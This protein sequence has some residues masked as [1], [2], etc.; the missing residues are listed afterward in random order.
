MGCSF[1]QWLVIN[2]NPDSHPWLTLKS[3]PSEKCN[4]WCEEESK[5]PLAF[6]IAFYCN[7]LQAKYLLQGLC[8]SSCS[9]MMCSHQKHFI[10]MS[11]NFLSEVAL[12]HV[13][14]HYSRIWKVE[15]LLHSM[16]AYANTEVSSYGMYIFYFYSHDA[17]YTS[18]SGLYFC[19]F[20]KLHF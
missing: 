19:S 12:A 5:T 7:I 10:A 15:A 17:L 16:Q 4:F 8:L 6:F 11:V 1:L 3:Y 13:F 2:S 14:C 20:K 18:S 9:Q